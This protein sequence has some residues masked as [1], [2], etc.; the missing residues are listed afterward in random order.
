M[1]TTPIFSRGRRRTRRTTGNERRIAAGWALSG[2]TPGKR[3]G[4]ERLLIGLELFLAL[5]AA[6]GGIALAF[7]PDGALLQADPAVLAGTPFADWRL[8]GLLLAGLGGGGMGLTGL[9]LWRHQPYARPMVVLSGIG[10]LVAEVAEWAMIGFQP[11]QA[12]CGC[13][14]LAM[15]LLGR[16]LPASRDSA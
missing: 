1:E 15:A 6:A 5:S 16:R 3:S 4:L 11:L 13:A 7:R 12:V 2:A 10:L 14:G 8:P 9:M